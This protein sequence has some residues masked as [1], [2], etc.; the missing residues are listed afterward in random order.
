MPL[1][2]D[3]TLERM[4]AEPPTQCSDCKQEI[5]RNYCR[6]CD[7]FFRQGQRRY[8]EALLVMRLGHFRAD[9]LSFQ[10]QTPY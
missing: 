4:R 7:E 6:E 2:D 3:E 8:L 5:R 9:H 10:I 1:L